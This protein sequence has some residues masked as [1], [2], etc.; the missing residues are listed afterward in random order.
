MSK[1]ARKCEKKWWKMSGMK[2]WVKLTRNQP[3]NKKPV[4][5]K[6]TGS[7]RTGPIQPFP[8]GVRGTSFFNHP[9][10]FTLSLLSVKKTWNPSPENSI[11]IAISS[12]SSSLLHL[13]Y[14][15]LR[16]LPQ[17]KHT[18]SSSPSF[19]TIIGFLVS[20]ANTPES[21]PSTPSSIQGSRLKKSRYKS[22]GATPLKE[23]I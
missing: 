18:I 19:S 8:P 16:S 11:L 10:P 13:L 5:S 6:W 1:N 17:R 9:L 23:V 7:K 2:N 4:K 3:K 22:K 14:L 20:N 15:S 12:S 21:P